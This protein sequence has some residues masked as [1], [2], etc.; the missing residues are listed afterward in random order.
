MISE[1]QEIVKKPSDDSYVTFQ[2]DLTGHIKK[3][4]QGWILPRRIQRNQLDSWKNLFEMLPDDEKKCD[5]LKD[6]MFKI[7]MNIIKIFRCK[8]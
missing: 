2:E 5:K 1:V 3:Y 6:E 4:V 8:K 7:L